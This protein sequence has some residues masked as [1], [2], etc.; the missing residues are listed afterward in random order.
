MKKRIFSV[1]LCLALMLSLLPTA[2]LAAKSSLPFTDV[3]SSDW[4]YDAVQYVYENSM[5][6]GTGDSTFSPNTTTTRGMIV[7]VLH[8]LEGCPN[9]AGTSFTDVDSGAYYATA[10][11]WASSRGIV[12]GYGNGKFG[13][14]DT[15]TREQMATILYRYAV[16]S[17]YDVSAKGD[18]SQFADQASVSSY[19]AEAMA[20]AV[21]VGLISGVGNNTLAPRNGATRAQ[22]A[23][24]LMRFCENV[25][26]DLPLFIAMTYKVTFDYNY[27]NAGTYKTVTVRGSQ[28][29]SVPAAPSRIGYTFEG[30]YTD[31]ACTNPYN[32]NSPIFRDITLYAKWVEAS[33]PDPV[34]PPSSTYT[35]TFDSN[36]GSAVASQTVAAGTT[37]AQPTDPTREGYYFLGW[38]SDSELT[39][40]YEFSTPVTADITLYAQWVENISQSSWLDEPAPDVEIYSFTTDTWNI[41]IG[42]SVPVTFTAEV[43]ANI[44]LSEKTISV[45]NDN[46]QTIGSMYDD[47]GN[48]DATAGDGIYTLQVS[49]SSET[50]KTVKYFAKYEDTLSNYVSIGYY[51]PY[52]EADFA[53]Y[54]EVQGEIDRL[55]ET[56]L[57]DNGYVKEDQFDDALAA[58]TGRLDTLKADGNVSSYEVMENEVCV[59]LTSGLSFSYYLMVEGMEAGVGTAKIATFQPFKGQWTSDL[60]NTWSDD[61]T[62]GSAQD[63]VTAFSDNYEFSL[64]A[65]NGAVS[66]DTFKT[67]ANYK[68]IIVNTHGGY[69][70]QNGSSMSVGQVQTDETTR[71]YNEN[72]DI[73]LGRVRLAS[74]ANQRIYTIT[75]GFID[76]YVGDMN[77]ALV[78]LG[79]CSSGKDMVDNI[80][81]T[82]ELAQS[83][84]NKGAAAVVGSTGTVSASYDYQ[85]GFTLFDNLIS[86][87]ENDAYQ[88]LSEALAKAESEYGTNDPANSGTSFDI[89]PANSSAAANYTLDRSGII[90]GSVKSASSSNGISNALIR[91]C[92]TDGND[93]S[94]TR[95]DSDG[96]YSL[97]LPAGDYIV[98]V[99]AGSYKSVKMAVTV[100]SGLTTWNETFLLVS[101]LLDFSTVSGSV[102][103]SITG[104]P[105]SGVT[106]TMRANWNNQTGDILETT[107]TGENGTYN[108]HY[109]VGAY[110]LEFYK[111]GYAVTY[112]NIVIG[113]NIISQDATISPIASD[114]VYRIVLSWGATPSDLDSHYNATTTT[115]AIEHV[116]YSNKEEANA[117]L[118]LDDITSYGPE[119]ITVTGFANLTGFKYS[120]HDYTNRSSTSSTALSASGAKVEVYLGSA[121]LKTYYIPIGLE[122]TV[123]NVFSVGSN[124]DITELNTFEY[125][126]NPSDVGN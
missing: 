124:G 1:V 52:T 58:L 59:V 13:P 95:T 4:Y 72:G 17:G 97:S 126:S 54:D 86:K 93:I 2:A 44:D 80:N 87:K 122:G 110:T 16:Y 60:L 105:V 51:T 98:K 85:I 75:G 18:L 41:Q 69:S 66:L 24:I 36:G 101:N 71:A 115:G 76:R 78:Y 79:S 53:L 90:A 63:I 37:V 32:F 56:Y 15:I 81:N 22:V 65:D 84:I 47:G 5:M 29:V 83:L 10:V 68:V 46:G 62:D 21:D 42:E 23:A 45:V 117:N 100:V 30:W 70:T 64:N 33:S 48:G 102:K 8:R 6:S 31:P 11:A 94:S 73:P 27:D 26:A 77:G 96:N 43:F 103:N 25:A 119:T 67:L 9:A 7:T 125:E 123:W 89:F 74:A 49:L 109:A 113:P 3:E 34:E 104:A 57:D 82:Y 61:M 20:W 112:K 118:D 121:L 108:I 12:D 50:S 114:G 38:Y 28:S 107:T 116:Y 88:T 39:D 111:P 92:D 19:A 35:V 55:M 106:V 99:S 14:N 91:V 40:V 120:V